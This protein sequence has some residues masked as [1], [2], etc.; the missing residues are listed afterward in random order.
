MTGFLIDQQL[1]ERLATHFRSR[2]HDAHH[3]KEYPGGA[4]LPDSEI[5][6]IADIEGWMVVTKDDDFRLLHAARQT[7][8]RLLIIACGNISTPDLLA[9][10]DANY[11]SLVSAVGKYRYVELHRE[12]VFVRDLD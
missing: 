11:D 12:G 3:V 8:R 5:A 6:A 7:P 1:P 2:G 10:V 4:T 9:L